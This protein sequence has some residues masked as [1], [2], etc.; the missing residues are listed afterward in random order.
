MNM[1][2]KPLLASLLLIDKSQSLSRKLNAK[3]QINLA[4][5]VALIY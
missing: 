2:I 1:D 4:L 5:E 3:Y